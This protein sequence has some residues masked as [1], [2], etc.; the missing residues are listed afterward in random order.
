MPVVLSSI[1]S[2]RKSRW[3]GYVG[4]L[5]ELGVMTMEDGESLLLSSSSEFVMG[6]ILKLHPDNPEFEKNFPHEKNRE[7]IRELIKECYLKWKYLL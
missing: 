7:L 4:D 3:R 2:V 5:M 6:E 1:S